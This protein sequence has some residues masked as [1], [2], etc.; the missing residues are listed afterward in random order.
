MLT[1]SMFS[2]VFAEE[3]VE[4]SLIDQECWDDF[5][6][7]SGV[8]NYGSVIAGQGL[9]Q[10]FKP[11]QPC[12]SSIE[13]YLF[14][15]IGNTE[16]TFNV[17]IHES[18]Q[19]GKANLTTTLAESSLVKI[20]N[21]DYGW[22][23]FTF[24]DIILTPEQTYFIKLNGNGGTWKNVYH[25]HADIYS[26][27]DGWK[28]VSSTDT[29]FTE[30]N[31][32]FFFKTFYNGVEYIPVAEAGNDIIT[33]INSEIFFN[34]NGSSDNG[35]ITNYTWDMGDGSIQFGESFYYSYNCI[36]S[37]LVRLVVFDE[38][39]L[40]DNDT[41]LVTIIE[42]P[43]E[44]PIADIKISGYYGNY[45]NLPEDHPDVEG[46][47]TGLI[48]GDSP[49]NHDWYNDSYFSFNRLDESLDFGNNF[50]PLDE[51]LPG[52]PLYFAVHWKAEFDSFADNYTFELGSD[53]DSWVFIDGE[54]V[55]DLGGIHALIIESYTVKLDAGHHTLDVYFAERHEVQSGFYF[56]WLSNIFV[57]IPSVINE[58]SINVNQSI[59]LNAL[60]SYDP[61]GIITNY[62]WDL[63]NDEL[64]YKAFLNLSY[65][66]PGNYILKLT[67]FDINNTFANKAMRINVLE[68][69]QSAY[70]IDEIPYQNTEENSI[71]EDIIEPSDELTVDTMDESNSVDSEPQGNILDVDSPAL[72]A[73]V[74]IVILLFLTYLKMKFRK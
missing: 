32:D 1:L 20:A 28:F 37:Y 72:I 2:Q 13:L 21:G 10:S 41:L 63:G 33:Y 60:D 5:D 30:T 18:T 43:N 74:L 16:L 15:G 55:T 66:K 67:V 39:G 36:G 44:A 34:G 65:L 19:Y 14:L 47:I 57:S 29:G 6:V 12:L 46:P 40:S 11:T 61:D 70:F 26:R 52:D 35:V 48:Q 53:D 23:E 42:Y 59:G 56:K 24:S 49:Y 69:Q 3:P 8:L 58:I 68:F 51:G 17:S 25:N 45:Y 71:G 64:Y 7:E 54:M 27:G 4:I 31:F 38:A 62:T 73:L 9:A 50:W 22:M